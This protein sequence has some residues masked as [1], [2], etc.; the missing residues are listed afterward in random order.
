LSENFFQTRLH[1]VC[2]HQIKELQ[3][4]IVTRQQQDFVCL[5]A[6]DL[7]RISDVQIE[8]RDGGIWNYRALAG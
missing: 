2:T 7:T 8:F 1:G 4:V 5:L 3:R 6:R